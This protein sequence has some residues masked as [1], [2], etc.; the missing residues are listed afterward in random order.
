MAIF[1]GIC[2]LFFYCYARPRYTCVQNDHTHQNFCARWTLSHIQFYT[3]F[4]SENMVNNRIKPMRSTT[5]VSTQKK[6]NEVKDHKF[7]AETKSLCWNICAHLSVSNTFNILTFRFLLFCFH[8]FILFFFF[9]S[10]CW[11][12]SA[13]VHRRRHSCV[14]N[15]VEIVFLV[16]CLR[17]YLVKFG[18]FFC[19][20]LLSLPSWNHTLMQMHIKH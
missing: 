3:I 6:R 14:A 4:A 9:L 7:I 16:I 5:R 18:I 8:W 12:Y 10:G 15:T 13:H 17:F 1:A 20:P 19:S 11:W 2:S